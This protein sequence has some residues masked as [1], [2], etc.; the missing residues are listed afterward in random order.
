[1]T[2]GN[3]I[4]NLRNKKGWTQEY[5]AEKMFVSR[6]SVSK[7]ESDR[8]MPD[9]E[10]IIIL[11]DLFGVSTDYLL[12]GVGIE[13]KLEE[14]KVFQDENSSFKRKLNIAQANDYI[15]IK[16]GVSFKY[17]LAV[18]LLIL[19]P[20]ALIVLPVL[21]E[22]MVITI[23]ENYAISYAFVVLFLFVSI[24][25]SIFMYTS[26]KLS[27]YKFIETEDFEF[28]YSVKD[29]ILEK[30]NTYKDKYVRGNIIATFILLMSVVPFLLTSFISEDDAY[31]IIMLG[32]FVFFVSVAVFIYVKNGLIWSA[33]ERVLQEGEYNKFRKEQNKRQSKISS[34][35]WPTVVALFLV[36][37]FITKDWGNSWII[38][39]VAALLFVAINGVINILKK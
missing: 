39:P 4:I 10:K 7:W 35:Y 17:A 21:S 31:I 19:S 24:A 34:V 22:N 11:S 33:Y 20:I 37:S 27:D 36:Y 5:L 3:R 15:D 8:S 1:M 9:L 18:M 30:K 16:I 14:K 6:Q 25:V 23:S 29:M 38:W 26:A 2:F 13:S 32:V 12:K 28:D